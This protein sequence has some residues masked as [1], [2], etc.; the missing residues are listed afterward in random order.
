MSFGLSEEALEKIRSVFRRYPEL[1]RA[2]IYGSRAKGTHRPGSDVD[3]T[4]MGEGLGEREL[5]RID[6][7][8]DELLLPYQFDRSLFALV[9]HPEWIDHIQRVGRPLYERGIGD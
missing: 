3:L 9:T 7:E 5:H 2:V 1:E 4:L 8:L 6:S